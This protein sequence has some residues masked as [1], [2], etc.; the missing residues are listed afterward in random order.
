MWSAATNSAKVVALTVFSSTRIRGSL[1]CQGD[2][3]GWPASP[4][5]LTSLRAPVQKRRILTGGNGGC[6]R[7]GFARDASGLSKGI[8]RIVDVMSTLAPPASV[9]HLI[10]ILRVLDALVEEL[11]RSRF[12]AGELEGVLQFHLSGFETGLDAF[13]DIIVHGSMLS[14]SGCRLLEAGV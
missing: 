10:P 4:H 5:F 8:L 2:E 14:G 9:Q 13:D 12:V 6:G 11:F 7:E 3:K 1:T